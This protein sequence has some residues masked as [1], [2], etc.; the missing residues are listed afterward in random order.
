MDSLYPE[1]NRANCK[2]NN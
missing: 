1:R 2:A